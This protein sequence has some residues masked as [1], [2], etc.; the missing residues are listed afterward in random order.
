[1]EQQIATGFHRNTQINQEGGIDPEQFRV[2]SVID[3]V[4]TT[5]TVF[6]A[7]TLDCAQ[8]H[9]HKF[10]P[11]THRE[12][13]QMFAF[14]NSS[15]HDGH[16]KGDFGPVLELP[17]VAEKKA[18]E[19]HRERVQQM[20]AELK[21]LADELRGKAGGWEGG[22]DDAAPQKLKA[23][24]QAAL[25]VQPGQRAAAQEDV[26]FAAFRDQDEGYRKLQN[27]LKKLKS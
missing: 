19:T 20:E 3:R 5:A 23:E 10:D 18:L 16:G 11:F 24:V 21:R 2:E 15:L 6:L 12:Y 4:S 14:F 1:I 25:A 26:V 7:V 17:T 13:Y 27:R 8:C 22:L 9:D